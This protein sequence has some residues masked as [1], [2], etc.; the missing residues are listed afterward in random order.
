LPD[1]EPT[2]EDKGKTEDQTMVPL[3]SRDEEEKIS[4]QIGDSTL[5]TYYFK[6]IGI[7]N[8]IVVGALQL[9][10]VIG[11]NFPSELFC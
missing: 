11:A 8:L 7:F 6:T 10:S 1:Q 2:T 3:N 9:L 4:R 5:W